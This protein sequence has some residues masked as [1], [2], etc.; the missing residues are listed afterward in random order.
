MVSAESVNFIAGLFAIILVASSMAYLIRETWWHEYI[1]KV[2]LDSFSEG[3]DA[4]S[5]H[6]INA[7]NRVE[8]EIAEQNKEES[9]A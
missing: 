3:W 6:M 7:K 8:S 5:H 2:K 9:N 4:A 1:D